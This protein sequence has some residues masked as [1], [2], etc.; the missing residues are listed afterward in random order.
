MPGVAIRQGEEVIDSFEEWLG[1]DHEAP[2]FAWVHLYDA[3]SP[4]VPT[5]WSKERLAGY[6]GPLAEGATPELTRPFNSVRDW[7]EDDRLAYRALYCGALRHTDRLFGRILRTLRDRGVE[8][9]TMVIVAGDHGQALGDSGLCGHGA[10]LLE[11]VLRTALIVRSPGLPSG[12]RHEGIVGLIDLQPTILD[13]FDVPVPEGSGGRSLVPALMREQLPAST[14][15]V[16]TGQPGKGTE[17]EGGWPVQALAV[18]HESWKV[19][20]EAGSNEPQ[21]VEPALWRKKNLGLG[22]PLELDNSLRER[23]SRVGMDYLHTLQRKNE[24]KEALDPE[25]AAELEALGYGGGG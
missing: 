17:L 9:D 6:E 2:F 12:L 11:D 21:V 18:L 20:L 10:T 23:L 15:I 4:Y 14:Y 8:Q 22:H 1:Q 13:A 3:R 16:E 25:F 5:N 19:V 7:P 24:P